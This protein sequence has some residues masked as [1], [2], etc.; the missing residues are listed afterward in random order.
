MDT[1]AARP[2]MRDGDVLKIM[3]IDDEANDLAML[4]RYAARAEH[5]KCHLQ[6]F[7]AVDAAC[8]AMSANLPDVVIVDDSI[9]GVWIA[10]QIMQQLRNQG[11]TGGF[12]VLSGIKRPGRSQHLIRSGAFYHFDKNDLTFEAF[13]GLIDMAMASGRLMR[14]RRGGA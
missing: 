9:D 11:Y 4:Q 10:D 5:P 6:A 13:M 7:S 12:A 3:A 14:F 2:K 1:L 8:A